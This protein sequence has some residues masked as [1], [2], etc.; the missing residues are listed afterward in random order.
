MSTCENCEVSLVCLM[1]KLDIQCFCAKCQTLYLT[2]GRNIP[3]DFANKPGVTLS[4]CKP[5]QDRMLDDKMQEWKKDLLIKRI[6]SDG[7]R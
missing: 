6:Q 1:G 5:C 3:C 2:D 4:V 7:S